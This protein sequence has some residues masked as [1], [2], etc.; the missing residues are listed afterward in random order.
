MKM[1]PWRVA[2]MTALAKLAGPES[3]EAM[4]RSVLKAKH[5]TERDA[6]ERALVAV[7]NR[8][9]DPAKRPEPML[10]A[11]AKFDAKDQ[12]LLL[13]T[14]G[15]LGGPDSLKI[16]E[17]A[18]ADS[19]PVRHDAGLRAL[20]NWPDA[21]VAAR[22][23][24]L[25]KSADNPE[26]GDLALRALFRVAALHDKRTMPTARHAQ[27]RHVA[28]RDRFR[29]ATRSSSQVVR[30]APSSRYVSWCR[31][32]HNPSSAGGLRFGD[33]VG[34]SS[35]VHAY[36]HEAEFNKALD[37][38]IPICKDPDVLDHAKRYRRNQT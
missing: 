34:P 6:A 12:T 8:I 30:F 4:A 24:A 36:P 31:I 10:S 9:A 32:C 22:L 2:A 35:G 7:C 15:R 5:G 13:S 23:L 18:I 28:G 14:L 11:Y 37:I 21:T 1:P 38:V 3:V 29:G 33:R 20:C 27:D 25:T 16:I 26:H 19:D 17:S